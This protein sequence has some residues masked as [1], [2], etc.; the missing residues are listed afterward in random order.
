MLIGYLVTK[1]VG[2]FTSGL[3]YVHFIPQL[4]WVVGGLLNMIIAYVWIF[5]LFKLLTL[6]PIDSIQELFKTGSFPR[7]IVE[8]SPILS[9]YFNQMWIIDLIQ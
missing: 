8:K 6:I 1:L 2:I 9:N 5:L 3:R 4:D 7:W